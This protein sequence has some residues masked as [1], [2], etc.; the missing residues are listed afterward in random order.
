M[1]GCKKHDSAEGWRAGGGFFFCWIALRLCDKQYVKKTIYPAKRS[2]GIM[3]IMVLQ[4]IS[5][6]MPKFLPAIILHYVK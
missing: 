2:E 1:A 3:S 4:K 5:F 6:K